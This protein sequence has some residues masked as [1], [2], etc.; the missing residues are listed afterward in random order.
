MSVHLHFAIER[1][2]PPPP[3]PLAGISC[4]PAGLESS[5]KNSD[6]GGGSW[7][8]LRGLALSEGVDCNLTQTP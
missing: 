5:T 6:Q 2:T 4:S 8:L 1:G 3:F 7:S